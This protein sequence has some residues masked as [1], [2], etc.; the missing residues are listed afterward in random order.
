MIIVVIILS[1]VGIGFTSASDNGEELKIK[2]KK[3]ILSFSEV[4]IQ[5]KDEYISLKMDETNTFLRSSEKPLLPALSKT[6]YFPFGTKIKDVIIELGQVKTEHVSKKIEPS[7]KAYPLLSIRQPLN[8]IVTE[9]D[10]IYSTSELYPDRWYDYRFGCGLQKN[11]RVIIFNFVCYPVRYM[12]NEDTIY[13]LDDVNIEIIYEEADFTLDAQDEK[14]LLIITPLRYYLNLM[15][16][17]WHKQRHGITTKIKTAEAIYL[18]SS[19]RDRQEKI[20]N[21]I[22]SAIESWDIQYVL[23]VGGRLKGG[24]R[25]NIPVRYSNLEDRGGWNETYVSDLYY[26]DIYRVNSK[27]FEIE[28]EDWDSN[29]NNVFAEWKWEWRDDWGWWSS[30]VTS[31]DE[32]DLYPDVYIGRLACL[33][34]REVKNVV[35]KIIRYERRDSSNKEWFMRMLVAGG[36]TVPY[37]DGVNE[38]ENEND[39]A[40]AFMEPLG[41]NIDRYWASNGKLTNTSLI[42]AIRQGAGFLYCAGHGSPVVWATHPTKSTAWID[43]LFTTDMFLLRNRYKEPVCVVGGCHNSQFDCGIPFLLGGVLE[44][45][46][47]YFIWQDDENVMGKYAWI[48]R[49]WSWNLVKQ[50]VG[51]TIAS[52]GNTGLGWGSGGEGSADDLDGW[53]STHFFDSYAQ[54]QGFD[55]CTLGMVH[56]ATLTAYVDIFSPNND[57][58]DRKTVEQWVLLGDPS[59]KIGGY[60]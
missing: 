19:G 40:A 7:P 5:P 11:E 6:I 33:N 13:T 36:D 23:L 56:S 12:P 20:K 48:S 18:G 10:D 25:Y 14:Q 16:L 57:E 9:E 41:F 24:F 4:E 31:K 34:K 44:L 17:K 8:E 39:I 3:E 54:L 58:L 2:T 47:E 46:G 1:G 49:C 51:G 42:S 32:L 38:G 52:I 45:G 59:L 15:P 29:Q 22:K 37:G 60:S 30:N 26:S 50:R 53:I 28:F 27:T 21:Y 43:A 55:N 35:R